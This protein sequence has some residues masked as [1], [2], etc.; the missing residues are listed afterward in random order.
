[1]WGRETYSGRELFLKLGER[2]TL[3]ENS[4]I[5]FTKH[6][7]DMKVIVDLADILK[8]LESLGRDAGRL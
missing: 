1:M 3:N 5:Y 6:S 4:T 7:L 2:H 8:T